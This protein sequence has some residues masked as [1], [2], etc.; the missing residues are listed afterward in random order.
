MDSSIL[1][2]DEIWFLHVCHHI[3]N[4]LYSTGPCCCCSC[5]FPFNNI[6]CITRRPVVRCVCVV[7]MYISY[8]QLEF[9]TTCYLYYG[10]GNI[11]HPVV[12][13]INDSPIYMQFVRLLNW[14]FLVG[15][16][17]FASTSCTH[18]AHQPIVCV[19]YESVILFVDLQRISQTTQT[20]TDCT[21]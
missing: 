1:A 21:W 5:H 16:I 9:F 4:A 14:T 11:W 2:K 19:W 3:S 18:F 8:R 15:G 10:K 7:C 13:F 12:D 17:V 6:V 20:S